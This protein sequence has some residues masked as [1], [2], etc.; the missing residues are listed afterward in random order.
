MHYLYLIL[1]T[2]NVYEISMKDF[3]QFYLLKYLTLSLGKILLRLN[4][5]FI[6]PSNCFLD[7]DAVLLMPKVQNK[8]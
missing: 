8:A 3:H 1:L 4:F 5:N 6:S 7:N 2:D